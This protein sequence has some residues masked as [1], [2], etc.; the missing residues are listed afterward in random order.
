MMDNGMFV[1]DANEIENVI[2]CA[3]QETR[4]QWSG[5]SGCCAGEANLLM[6]PKHLKRLEFCLAYLPNPI[7]IPCT[8]LFFLR[9]YGDKRSE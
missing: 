1:R 6:F 8:P 3:E 5:N 7:R 2:V 9:S 4:M